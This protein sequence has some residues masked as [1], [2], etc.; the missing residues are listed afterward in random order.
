MRVKLAGAVL[1]LLVTAAPS[2]AAARAPMTLLLATAHGRGSVTFSTGTAHLHG[3]IWLVREGGSGTAHG[4]ATVACVGKMTDT[5]KG[6]TD[7]W[8]QFQIGSN[9]RQEIWRYGGDV[10]TVTVSLK[11]KGVLTVALRGY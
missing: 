4:K 10:C 11:G 2:V 5:G 9:G 3:R 7:E 8:F 6:Y 1:L